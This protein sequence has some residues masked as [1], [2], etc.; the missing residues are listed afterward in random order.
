MP[1]IRYLSDL[2]HTGILLLL[3]VGGMRDCPRDSVVMLA[4]DD[5]QRSTL[6]ILRI[7]LSFRP[8]VE[9]GTS[10]L[11]D[12]RTGTRNRILLV[13]LVSFALFY[14]VGK[15]KTELLVG[16]RDSAC[17]VERVTQHSRR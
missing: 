16:K 11:E 2:G 17:V 13:Q 3:L 7:D 6:R 5:Q 14:N 15:G 10:R 4:R 12:R 9:I 8:W 1:T